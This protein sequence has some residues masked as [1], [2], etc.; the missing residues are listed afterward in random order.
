MRKVIFFS[1]KWYDEPQLTKVVKVLKQYLVEPLETP[2]SNPLLDTR[3]YVFK[4]LDR[5]DEVL[6]KNLVT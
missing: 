2:Y 4:V 3:S 1:R 6:N 5:Y